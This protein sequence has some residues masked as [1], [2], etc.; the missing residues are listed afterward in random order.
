MQKFSKILF[1][2]LFTTL[3]IFTLANSSKTDSLLNILENQKGITRMETLRQITK[4]YMNN[5][6]EEAIKFASELLM[7]AEEEGNLKY[8]DLA[9]SFLGEAYF[10]MD[11]IEKSIE[12]F[13]K[14][15]EINI[16]QEV[17]SAIIFFVSIIVPLL[18][19]AALIE[20]YVT[21]FILYF[22]TST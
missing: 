21:S 5:S 2:F 15:L 4:K 20:T 3:S 18:F 12:Y 19:V 10:Y 9:C 8:T 22:M 1:L 6:V 14:F 7:I 17:I 11:E 16:K 13:E